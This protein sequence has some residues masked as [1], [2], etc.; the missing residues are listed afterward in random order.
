MYVSVPKNYSGMA[1]SRE[2]DVKPPPTLP[3]LPHPKNDE[4]CEKEC[5]KCAVKE[6]NP[7]SC[8]FEAFRGKDRGGFDTEDFLLLG[9]IALMLNKEGNEDIVLILA[10]LLLA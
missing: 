9:L 4:K 7:L 6:K 1:F 10:I 3:T 5:E 2:N 8:L